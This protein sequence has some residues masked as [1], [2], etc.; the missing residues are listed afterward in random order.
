MPRAIHCG[1]D[2]GDLNSAKATRSSGER[3]APEDARVRKERPRAAQ[4]IP[5]AGY[6]FSLL[7]PILMARLR[8]RTELHGGS[9]SSA[10]Q[11]ERCRSPVLRQVPPTRSR[12]ARRYVTPA[13]A[14]RF[15]LED[16]IGKIEEQKTVREKIQYL[17]E[18][19]RQKQC[20]GHSRRARASRQQRIDEAC[21]RG[22]HFPVVRKTTETQQERLADLIE[23]V[24]EDVLA[25]DAQF[26]E[27][28]ESLSIISGRR[29]RVS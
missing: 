25:R 9:A 19:L 16:G 28:V 24:L 8:P 2:Y 3:I 18:I 23:G 17:R 15:T 26:C 27:E 4:Y 7:E 1:Y 21:S 13:A 10:L 20:I 11:E 29:A 6:G 14:A 12:G 5:E 22:E